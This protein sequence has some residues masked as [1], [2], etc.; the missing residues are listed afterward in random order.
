MS[1]IRNKILYKSAKL[2]PRLVQLSLVTLLLL[3]SH[4]VSGQGVFKSRVSSDCLMTVVKN[5]SL[6]TVDVF[7]NANILIKRL[8]TGETANFEDP[9]FFKF[10]N[11][12]FL[13][14][15]E[16]VHG[17]AFAS[18]EFIYHVNKNC[19]LDSV[20][21]SFAAGQYFKTAPKDETILKGEFRKFSDNEITF[22]FGVWKIGDPSCCPSIGYMTGKYKLVKLEGNDK[23]KYQMVV[24][25]QKLASSDD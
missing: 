10:D 15:Q 21:F 6:R 13:R 3:I 5:D 2:V 12:N 23:V 17:T 9:V 4:Q 25:E 14:V 16:T 8:A 22:L 1:S 7:N 20:Q 18:S 11:A 24:S 19:G